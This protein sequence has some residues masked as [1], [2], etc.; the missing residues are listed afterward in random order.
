[1]AFFDFCKFGFHVY[2]ARLILQLYGS[3]STGGP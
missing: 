2:A 1:M 3:K